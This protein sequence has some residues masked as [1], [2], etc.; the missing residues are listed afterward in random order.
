LL[1]S[2]ELLT[3]TVKISF[4]KRGCH[5]RDHMVVGFT[6]NCTISVYHLYSCEFEP[7]WWRGVLKFVSDL[8]QVG[9]FHQVLRFPPPLKLT[10]MI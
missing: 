5:G 1:I 6:T 7:R 2:V 10:V 3:I 8:W 9:G 4:Y